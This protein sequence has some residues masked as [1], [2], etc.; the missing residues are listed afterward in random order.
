MQSLGIFRAM[1]GVR[2][3]FTNLSNFSIFRK[4]SNWPG[5][6]CQRP[7]TIFNRAQPVPGPT[8]TH[9]STSYISDRSLRRSHCLTV[10][11][12]HHHPTWVGGLIPAPVLVGELPAPISPPRPHRLLRSALTPAL[13]LPPCSP[14]STTGTVPRCRAS[15]GSA[16]P[17]SPLHLA[18]AS[19]PSRRLSPPA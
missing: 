18:P 16:L 19:S 5:L 12:S 14:L 2:F 8:R 10:A 11:T 15:Q 9:Q 6:T 1:K 4:F 17:S 13:R 3:E 7:S